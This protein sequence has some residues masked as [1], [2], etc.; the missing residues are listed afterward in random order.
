[1]R[2]VDGVT[3]TLDRGKTLGIVGES[4]SGKTV[5][6][7]SIMGLLPKRGHDPRG[8][9]ALRGRGDSS[10]STTKADA[11]VLGLA[12]GD[13]LPGPDD[14]AEPRDEDRQPDHRVDPPAPRRRQGLRERARR[15][16]ARVGAHPRARGSGS[17]STRTSCRAAC[18]SGCASRSRSPAVPKLLFADEPTTAL[19]VTVQAQVL[20]LMAQQQRERFMAMVLITHDLGVVAG[21]ADDIAVMYAGRI[22]EKAPTSVLFSRHEDAV[23]RGAAVLDPEARRP[24]SHTRLATIPGRPPDLVNPPVG[25]KFAPRCAYVQDRCLEEE[26]PLLD[27]SEPGPRVPVLVPGRHA[28]GHRGARRATRPRRHV[29]PRA[30]RL[31]QA[32]ERLMAGSGTAHLR[33]ADGTRSLRVEHLVVEF[34]VGATGLKVNAVSD[35]SASTSSRARRWDSSASRAAASRRPGERSCSSRPPK[36]GSVMFDGTELTEL[37]GEAL[38]KM[39]PR[40]Q[41]IF[42]DPI[43]SLNPRRRVREIVAR[44]PR[45]LVDRR[46]GEPRRE[47]RR[48]ARRRRHR[49]RATASGART[50]SRVVS[51][52][53]SRSRGPSSPSPKLIICDEPVS[54]LDVSVQAQILNLLQDMKQRYGLTL[55]FIAHDLAVVKNVS[56]RVDGDV[57]RQGVRGR[58]DPTRSTSARR[59]R[60]PPRCSPRSRC[61]TRAAARRDEGAGRRDPL[62]ACTRRAAAGSAP[63]ARKAEASAAR[64]RSP[65]SARS[66]PASSSPAT[67][68]SR[69]ASSST[70]RRSGRPHIGLGVTDPDELA[71]RAVGVVGL[72]A[73]DHGRRT[74]CERRPSCGG[75]R[76]PSR[77]RRRRTPCTPTV[78][79]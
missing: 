33:D 76:A 9:G 53:A 37:K 78:L 29:A 24:Q 74:N 26:P 21:R 50:S 49:P 70:S 51:A 10:T 27:G 32:G 43:S 60:T 23:H 42:Q 17:R 73:L 19:D 5:L 66:R 39:R 54:A 28:R 56:D 2:A 35:V 22:V 31:A 68:R 36:S 12:D 15:E 75:A 55:V 59:T 25:C 61:P 45:D 13:G 46:Q 16:P 18:A 20:D 65:S 79:P 67:S 6:S 41:M 71:Q 52:S 58:A 64:P 44:G 7:R 8:V 4:G 30:Q 57:P 47:G 72:G 77:G 69:R 38:R 1:M 11:R 34:P 62:T 14:V 40:M 48:G 63:G 3:F